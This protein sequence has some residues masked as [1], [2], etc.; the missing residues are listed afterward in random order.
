MEEIHE[1]YGETVR[2]APN[3]LSFAS[4]QAWKDVYAYRPGMSEPPKDRHWYFS[5]SPDILQ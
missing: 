1:T 2:L 3:E 5:E 4:D